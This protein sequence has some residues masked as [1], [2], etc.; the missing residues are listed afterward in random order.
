MDDKTYKALTKTFSKNEIK[1]A[2]KGKFGK[3]VPHHLITKRLNEV[4]HDGWTFEILREIKDKSGRCSGVVAR[5][6]IDGLGFR[7]EIG[8]TNA[9]QDGRNTASELIKLATS[10]AILI[11]HYAKEEYFNDKEKSNISKTK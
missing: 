11:T 6:T 4:M 1:D 7:D 8:D 5:M 2:P 10:D 9:Q 3:Y